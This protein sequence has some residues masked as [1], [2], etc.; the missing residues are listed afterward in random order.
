MPRKPWCRE[1]SFFGRGGSSGCSSWFGLLLESFHWWRQTEKVGL[2]LELLV[3][4][5]LLLDYLAQCFRYFHNAHE[6]FL[7]LNSSFLSLNSSLLL[8]FCHL[9]EWEAETNAFRGKLFSSGKC[10][11]K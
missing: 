8:V 10:F 11:L 3:P 7:S 5:K 2:G 1:R 6:L 9:L 4:G